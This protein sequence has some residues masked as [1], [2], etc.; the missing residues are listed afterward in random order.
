[1]H[2]SPCQPQTAGSNL[3][4]D[5]VEHS[6]H[7]MGNIGPTMKTEQAALGSKV[8]LDSLKATQQHN[9]VGVLLDGENSLF[10][11][12]GEKPL[13]Q[14]WRRI[15]KM[16]KRCKKMLHLPN[17]LPRATSPTET[18]GHFAWYHL[19]Y[20]LFSVVLK[21]QLGRATEKMQNKKHSRLSPWDPKQRYQMKWDDRKHWLWNSLSHTPMD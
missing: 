1:M 9:K 16:T 3:Y 11:H 20:V 5:C 19:V 12:P 7:L 8:S 6:S 2:S 13:L 15:Q 10:T 21:G 17:W 18:K 14:A 4:T